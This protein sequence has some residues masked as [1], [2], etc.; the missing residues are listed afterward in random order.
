MTPFSKNTIL[1]LKHIICDLE[2]LNILFDNFN[3][4]E[5][6]DRISLIM[7]FLE[8]SI[9]K[10]RCFMENQKYFDTSFDC[11]CYKCNSIGY[12]SFVK[13]IQDIEINTEELIQDLKDKKREIFN[14]WIYQHGDVSTMESRMY[15][16]RFILWTQYFMNEFLNALNDFDFYDE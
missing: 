8:Y 7:Y 12:L 16:N 4:Y 9:S 11:T 14:S 2:N 15:I 13:N 3:E 5:K 10:F 6:N 1:C